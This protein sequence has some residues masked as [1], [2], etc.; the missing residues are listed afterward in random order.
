MIKYRASQ[1]SARS[2]LLFGRNSVRIQ[3]GIPAT[4]IKL[5]VFLSLSKQILGQ[6]LD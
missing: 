2:G 4:M 1:C 6:Y 5:V 3:R